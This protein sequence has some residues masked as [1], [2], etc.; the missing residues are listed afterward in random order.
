MSTST[1]VLLIGIG[2][3][4]DATA[5]APSRRCVCTQQMAALLCLKRRHGR[6]LLLNMVTQQQ[7]QVQD[8][9]G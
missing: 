8:Q 6:H 1:N 2:E 9:D 5:Y 3:L 4:A 7:E